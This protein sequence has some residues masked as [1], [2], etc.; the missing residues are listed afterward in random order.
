MAVTPGRYPQRAP[1]TPEEATITTRAAI[2]CR[3]SSD[4]TGTALGVARQ[5][6]DCR[7]LAAQR[8][9][10]VVAV[11]I[12]ND[13]SAY[14]GKPRLGYRRLLDDIAQR[15]C[16]V[17]V[18][19]HPD[20]LHRAPRELEDFVDAL[21]AADV[22]VHTVTAG[23]VDLSTPAGRL[24]AR[25]VGAVARAE[26]EHK[27]A[28]LRR[29]MVEL[30]AAGKVTGGGTRPFGWEP[31]FVTIRESEAA[32]IRSAAAAILAGA[33]V[34]S[35][36]VDWT[37]RGVATVTGRGMWTNQIFIRMICSPRN[38][39]LKEHRG[40]VV[41]PAVWPAIVDEATHRRLVAI[42]QTPGRSRRRSPSKYL[43]TGGVAICGVCGNQLFARPRDDGRRCYVCPSG[44]PWG[45]CGKIRILAEPLE[46]HVAG[47]VLPGLLDGQFRITGSPVDTDALLAALADTEARKAQLA[48]DFYMTHDLTDRVQFEAASAALDAR[49]ID[50]RRQL[51]D[52]YEQDARLAALDVRTVGD[53]WPSMPMEAKHSMML[54]LGVAVTI[55][56]AVRGRNFFDPDR[57]TVTWPT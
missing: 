24:T 55:A 43:L 41:G 34:R 5:E 27:S 7:T 17:V 47:R 48:A 39:G 19:W 12:D 2:Y 44:P 38:A 32:E 15:R 22:T 4:P 16:D 49:I 6:A 9:W 51:G 30:A 20:R 50:L 56:P 46:A 11:H 13:R 1:C 23:A 36:L 14:S 52:G 28:R 40:N 10:D 42:L 29:K 37:N 18:A 33:S 54:A 8:G 57:V 45:G 3:I 21:I 26:S 53:R 25:V 35:I 31:D